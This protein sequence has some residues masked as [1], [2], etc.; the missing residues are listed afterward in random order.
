MTFPC[1]KLQQTLYRTN[2]VVVKLQQPLYR[3]S[4]VMIQTH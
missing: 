4:T 3:S 1:Q 2:A